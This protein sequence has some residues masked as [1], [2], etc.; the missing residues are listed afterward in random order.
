MRAKSQGP[1]SING[2]QFRAFVRDKL[3][4][5]LLATWFQYESVFFGC[6]EV[7]A[8]NTVFCTSCSQDHSG[9]HL[10]RVSTLR[11]PKAGRKGRMLN[12]NRLQQCCFG[13]NS[14]PS[15]PCLDLCF[16]LRFRADGGYYDL[17]HAEIG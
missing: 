13:C 12:Y 11:P 5:K 1:T 9:T 2:M 6:V 14:T 7:Q 16:P 4:C 10:N 15:T 8:K 3:T 17:K